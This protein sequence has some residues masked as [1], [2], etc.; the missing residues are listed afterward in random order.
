MS[1]AGNDFILI[2]GGDNP[3]FLPSEKIIK[4]YFDSLN[5]KHVP[6]HRVQEL[7]IHHNLLQA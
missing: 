1:G 2:D 5:N 7:E 4:N 3:E 6:K